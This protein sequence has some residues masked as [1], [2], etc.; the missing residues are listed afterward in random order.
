[1]V[2]LL[3]V[4]PDDDRFTFEL[5]P[6]Q[7]LDVG[8]RFGVTANLAGKAF[9]SVR[10]DV[11]ARGDELLATETLK[12]PGALPDFARLPRAS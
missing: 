12:V 2:D 10:L 8:F 9:A 7:A 5:G 11:A 6:P 1:L 4:D 3:A